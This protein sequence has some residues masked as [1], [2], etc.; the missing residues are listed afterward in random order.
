MTPAV[1]S[2]LL[3]ASVL[4]PFA[5]E[6]ALLDRRLETLRRILPDGANPTGDAALVTEMLKGVHLVTYEAFARPPLESGSRGDVLVDVT[7]T[8]RFGD[9]DRFFRQVALSP[10]LIDV[11]SVTLAAA[12]GDLVRLTALVHL[13]YRPERA[14]LPPP[15]EGLRTSLKDVARPQAQAF[16]RDQSISLAKAESIVALRRARRNPRMFLSEMAAVVRERPVILKEAVLGEEFLI[17]GLVVGEGPMRALESRLERGFFRIAEVLMA[18]QGSCYRFEARGRSPVVGLEAEIPLPGEDPFRLDDSPCQVDRDSG[19]V[20]AIRGPAG[21]GP[22]KGPHTVRLRDVDLADLFHALHLA[23]GDSFLVD[24]D[25]RGRVSVDLDHLTLDEMLALLTRAGLRVAGAGRLHRVSR[26]ASREAAAAASPPAAEGSPRG[27]FAL[28]RAAVRDVLAILGEADPTLVSAAPRS[29]LGRVTVWTK[30]VPMAE[31]RAAV[32]DAAG[33]VERQEEGRRVLSRAEA[34]AEPAVPLADLPA[35]RR[36]AM[37]PQDLALS[38]FQ[39]A[40]V[41]ATG[42]GWTALA[43]LPTGTLGVYR[44][45]DRLADATVTEV[46]S[47]DVVLAT[48]EGPVRLTLSAIP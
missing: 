34:P 35:E 38:E 47:T 24:D 17:R 26:G 39:V 23:T 32:V 36:L 33:L 44:V 6:R 7:A 13:P 37:R 10:R 25:V 8:G 9:I 3:A 30:D 18:R 2:L 29:G 40:G 46:H 28:K 43:Y 31:L 12:P 14:P 16:L 27:T 41:V 19:S 45:G 11:E 1:A 15:P 4:R 48:D 20:L 42:G 5:D 22:G 21:K